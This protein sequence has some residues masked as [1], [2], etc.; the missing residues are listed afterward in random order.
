MILRGMLLI[1][2][3][4]LILQMGRAVLGLSWRDGGK[5]RSNVV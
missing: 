3:R 5:G 1:L 2:L 4:G